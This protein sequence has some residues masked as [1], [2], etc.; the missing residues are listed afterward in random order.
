MGYC[1]PADVET[2]GR[3][4][5]L[6]RQQGSLDALK[7]A[8]AFSA[9]QMNGTLRFDVSIVG[10]RK[11]VRSG[12]GFLIP[13]KAITPDLKPDRVIVPALGTGRPEQL[14][15]ALARRDVNQAKEQLLKWHAAGARIAA[16]CI[17]TFVLAETGLLD[18]R[19]ATTT[20][21]PGRQWDIS[22]WRCG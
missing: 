15:P 2:A 14:I 17:G 7:L 11:R 9:S 19:K 20:Q 21:P 13:V 12:Q 3:R 16:S 10:V 8:D 22:I 4:R 1:V 18:Q 6:A 5:S